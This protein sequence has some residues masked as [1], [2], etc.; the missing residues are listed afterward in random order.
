MNDNHR[1]RRHL[2]FCKRVYE[3][4]RREGLWPLSG[5]K[6]QPDP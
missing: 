2:E 5:W 3:R 1:L 6:D 4:M